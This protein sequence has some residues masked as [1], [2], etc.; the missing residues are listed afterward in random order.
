VKYDGVEKMPLTSTTN[1]YTIKS[2]VHHI[3]SRASSGHYTADALRDKLISQE[4]QETEENKTKD[5][6]N[7][8]EK[9]NDDNYIEP[10]VWVSY[11]DD[12]VNV[13]T[14]EKILSSKFKQES[15]YMVLYSL[16]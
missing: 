4:D 7:L 1:E 14:I 6:Q 3:G 5:G 15:A 13:T 12:M 9:K 2:I 8:E 11:D 16:E 10:P